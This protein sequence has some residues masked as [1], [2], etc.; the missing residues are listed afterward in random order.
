MECPTCLENL[1][2]YLDDELGD[3]D[4]ERVEAHLNSCNLCA[5]DLQSLSSSYQ[6]V[7]RALDTINV[8]PEIWSRIEAALPARSEPTRTLGWRTTVASLF[9]PPSRRWAAS[10]AAVALMAAFAFLRT[11]LPR[12]AAPEPESLRPQLDAMVQE[13][14]RED[15]LRHATPAEARRDTDASNPFTPRHAGLDYNPFR[16]A[17]PDTPDS[18]ISPIGGARAVDFQPQEPEVKESR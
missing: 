12:D 16:L 18:A 9:Q 13:M 3:N 14:D 2:A 1:T 17:E 4:R 7:D 15:G 6:V 8:G 11:P 10:F 5:A